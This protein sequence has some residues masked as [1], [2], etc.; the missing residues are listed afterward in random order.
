MS[1]PVRVLLVPAEGEI[2]SRVR[3]ALEHEAD[4]LEVDVATTAE[5]ALARLETETYDCVLADYPLSDATGTEFLAAVRE[6]DPV[7]PFVLA[8][9]QGSEA[10]ASEAVRRGVT[11][12][13]ASSPGQRTAKELAKRVRGAVEGTQTTTPRTDRVPLDASSR[14]KSERR[15]REIA[16]LS[17]DAV[18]RIEADGTIRYVS[19][20]VEHLLGYAPA[21]LVDEPFNVLVDPDDLGTAVSG[22]QRVLDGEVVH[23]LSVV[24]RRQ[25]G[26]RIDTEVSASPVYR[27]DGV[28]IVQGFARD[29]TERRDR[30]RRLHRQEALLENSPDA[31]YV[32]DADGEITFQSQPSADVLGYE[33]RDLIGE[34]VIEYIHPDDRQE[35]LADF[36]YLLANPTEAVTTEYRYRNQD[37]DWRWMENRAVNLLE[38]PTVE[39]VLAVNRDVTERHERQRELEATNERLER[40]ASVVSHDLRNPLAVATGAIDLVAMDC[41]DPHLD[42]ASDALERMDAIIE[43]VL[44]VARHGDANLE[45]APVDLHD[46]VESCLRTL[47]VGDATVTF[48]ENATIWADERRLSHLVENLVRNAVEHGSTGSR[49]GSGDS[50]EHGATTTQPAAAGAETRPTDG[51][52]EHDDATE[53]GAVTITVGAL[54]D[55]FFVADDGPGIPE[56][57]RDR[58]FDTGHTTSETGTGFGLAIVQ[59]VAR[60]HG[61]TVTVDESDDGGAR[62]EFHGV[63]T[64]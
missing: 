6:R 45:P 2:A 20:A 59:D 3:T 63:R 44:A 61:W 32:T 31:F 51:P 16:E 5:A 21:D 28:H 35:V 14:R 11:D 37:G 9:G 26:V 56:R 41:D 18:F 23:D 58:V 62:F 47:D 42:R 27:G 19:P 39:G 30:E 34:N 7:L 8:T 57:E 15:F 53:R 52:G 64:E 10:V 60:E 40:F 17:P 55:G 4:V 1:E 46:L 54:D 49:T 13:V 33:R 50:V 25:D 43:D 12:Y 22:F 38:D 24:L 29:V 48:E 36:E